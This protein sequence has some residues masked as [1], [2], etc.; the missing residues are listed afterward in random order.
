MFT[1]A[2]LVAWSAHQE[3]PIVRED[4]GADFFNHSERLFS[5]RGIE[6][7]HQ[8]WR[9]HVVCQLRRFGTFM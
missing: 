5:P 9:T 3:D 4:L 6:I 7:Y 8:I 1:R 2:F